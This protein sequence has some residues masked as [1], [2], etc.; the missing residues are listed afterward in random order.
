MGGGG[1]VGGGGWLSFQNFQKKRVSDFAHI[2]GGVG[3]IG[4]YFRKGGVITYFHI[5]PFQCYLHLSVWCV[6]CLFT[7]F[8][9]VLFLFHRKNLV[10]QH[11]IKVNNF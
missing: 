1:G 4:G 7:P 2:K 9:S 5:N 10:L 3:K 8:L 11:L 6:C